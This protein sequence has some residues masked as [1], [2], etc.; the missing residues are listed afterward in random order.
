[1]DFDSETFTSEIR[2][3]PWDV[4]SEDYSNRLLR[5]KSWEELVD[6]LGGDKISEEVKKELGELNY[7][8]S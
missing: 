1:M 7:F 2:S 3:R 5:Q 6:R 8:S 4:T